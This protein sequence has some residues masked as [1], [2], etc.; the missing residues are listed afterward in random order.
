[1]FARFTTE[2]WEA[3]ALAQE[4]SGRL[5]HSW[6]GT[7]HLLLGLLRQHD[8]RARHVLSSLGVTHTSVQRAL[9][10][11]L[12][13]LSREQPLGEGD[14]EAL[15]SLGIDLQEVRRRVESAFGPGA[16]DQAI[17]GSCGLPMMPRLKQSLE[18]ADRAARPRQ[19]DTDYL[20]L[21][22]TAVRGALAIT[23]LQQLGVS[24]DMIRSA[25]K[26][27]RRRAG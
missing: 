25:V 20:L 21:G 18:H 11:N 3:M 26:E 17:P 6:L 5:R 14:E 7:E 9:V 16:L 12:G 13:E 19:I 8:T 10:G 23:L 15:R 22:I 2:A 24:T 27:Q 4:E 1:M